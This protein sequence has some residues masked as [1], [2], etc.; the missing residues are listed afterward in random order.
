MLMKGRDMN[1]RR[2][3]LVTA[4]T[5]L[6]A[7]VTPATVADEHILASDGTSTVNRYSDEGMVLAIQEIE[8]ALGTD[9]LRPLAERYE[10][11]CQLDPKNPFKRFLWAYALAD[12]SLALNEVT[13]VT[14]LDNKF[15]WAYLGMGTILDGWKVFDQAEKDFRIA[16]ELRPTIAI[17][18][19]RFG[20]L[21]LHKNEPA[22]AL[23]LLAAAVT[24]EPTS[25][26]YLLEL[27]RAQRDLGNLSD[28][29]VSYR[30]LIHYAPALFA[31][32]AE[33][34][35]LLIRTGDPASG[36]E[37][38]RMAAALPERT[39]EVCHAYAA[40]LVENKRLDE[41]ADAYQI[42][43]SLEPMNVACWRALATVAASEGRRDL[44]VSACEHVIELEKD[45]IEAHRFLAG[46]Y[47]QA[48]EIEK[49][50]PSFQQLHASLPDD[51]EALAGLAEIY[52]RG[53][54]P[55]RALEFYERL[56][57]LHPELD[58]VRA[59]R[60]RLFERFFIVADPI[61]GNTPQQVFA[62]NQEQVD[63]LFKMRLKE[64]PGLQ[65][66]LVLKVKVNNLGE[67]ED[68]FV[69]KDT[70]ADVV[71]GTSAF[72]NLKRSQFPKG[73]GATY[74]F[75]LSLKPAKRD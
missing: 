72:W 43:C 29:L 64:R 48:G 26:A 21:Y 61:R 17:G 41:A 39:F 30:T 22:K 52:E 3:M 14:K 28:A 71:L 13:T 73:M 68:V 45:D 49:A 38:Y 6:P 66:E 20:C 34:A 18:A 42:A 47:L 33:L 44:R 63:R 7:C 62:K 24:H 1:V 65:G 54:D 37:E 11:T 46:A 69:A 19:Y 32:H 8:A 56:I 16:M 4:W 27:A 15:Y 67:V 36:L 75:S 51:T 50:L 74:N 59:A 35:E 25:V 57:V 40:L 60:N 2:L 31:A 70:L 12:R 55:S 5:I 58:Q 10:R 9:R 23:P 53:D